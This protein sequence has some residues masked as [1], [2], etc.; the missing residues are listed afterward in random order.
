M[1]I[2]N[3]I[4]RSGDLV[5]KL[6]RD[7]NIVNKAYRSG[8]LIYQRSFNTPIYSK[9]YTTFN[10]VSGGNIYWRAYSNEAVRTIYISKNGGEWTEITST[11]GTGLAIAV[12]SGDVLRVKGYNT[13]YCEGANGESRFGATASFEVCGNILSLIYGDDFV[14]KDEVPSGHTFCY[15]FY[16][17]ST[18]LSI[19]N[20]ALP[21]KQLPVSCYTSM[22]H[23]CSNINYVKCLATDISKLSSTAGWLDGVSPNGTFVKAYGVEW[24]TGGSGIPSGWTVIEE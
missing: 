12:E 4:N 24:D 10:I 19:E 16:E 22:F 14:G 3:K 2:V 11:T 20:L 7:G 18:L 9:E 13:N 8:E 23:G 21:I 17:C 6:C 1:E 5:N 15:M